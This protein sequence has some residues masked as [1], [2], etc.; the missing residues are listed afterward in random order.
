MK[1]VKTNRCLGKKPFVI[2]HRDLALKKYVDKTI[3]ANQVPAALNL[4]TAFA[5]PDGSQPAWDGDALGN[6]SAGC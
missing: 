2:D 5:A 3:L 6:D 4:A 1:R